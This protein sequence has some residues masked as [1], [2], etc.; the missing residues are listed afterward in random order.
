MPVNPT[1]PATSE[2]DAGHVLAANAEHYYALTEGTGTAPAAANGGSAASFSGSPT[3]TTNAEGAALSIAAKSG[4]VIPAP[5]T[6]TGDFTFA[7]RWKPLAYNGSYTIIVD[8]PQRPLALFVSSTDLNYWNYSAVSIPHGMAVNGIYTLAVTRS[9]TLCTLYVD[10]TSL[11]TLSS[12]DGLTAISIGPNPSG[13]GN[14]VTAEI[15]GAATWS[16][17]LSPSLMT[18]LAADFWA[19]TRSGS[20]PAS[21]APVSRRTLQYLVRTGGI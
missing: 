19:P 20:T 3:W 2:W 12:S 15:L 6:T 18:D 7:M 9:G 5:V 13:G 4:I 16:A 10:G 17:A 14:G 8:T 21:V 1:K 11:G